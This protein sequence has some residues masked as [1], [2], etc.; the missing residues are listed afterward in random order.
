[1]YSSLLSSSCRR[2][3]C[4]RRLESAVAGARVEGR[5]KVKERSLWS[6]PRD[7]SLRMCIEALVGSKLVMKRFITLFW[8]VLLRKVMNVGWSG[9][10]RPFRVIS[11]WS[12]SQVRTAVPSYFWRWSSISPMRALRSSQMIV[13]LSKGMDCMVSMVPQRREREGGIGV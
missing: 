2:D 12:S 7:R 8:V 3:T 5:S 13:F 10:R 6:E 11:W 9:T 1:M 4:H